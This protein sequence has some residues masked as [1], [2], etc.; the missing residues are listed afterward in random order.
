MIVVHHFPSWFLL[1]LFMLF[2]FSF[3][4]LLLFLYLFLFF[5]SSCLLP[6]IICH[7]S[8]FSLCTS[9]VDCYFFQQT[10]W[11]PGEVDCCSPPDDCCVTHHPIAFYFCFCFSYPH[12]F[13]SVP[14]SHFDCYFSPQTGWWPGQVDHC[15]HLHRL[16]VSLNCTG[17]ATICFSSGSLLGEADHCFYCLPFFQL[18]LVFYLL[19]GR[20]PFSFCHCTFGFSSTA[21]VNC[22]LWFSL[23]EA[24]P[25]F[26]PLHWGCRY[27]FF[28][29]VTTGEADPCFY[30][31]PFLQ[32]TLVFY[33]LFF[34]G[35]NP[36]SFLPLHQP[37]QRLIVACRYLFF[38]QVTAGRSWRLFLLFGW[39]IIF[40]R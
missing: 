28:F 1:L 12:C 20:N 35:R 16:I 7:S 3:S 25:C 19:F 32:L 10:K 11:R 17:A 23:G 36:F 4:F 40:D 34:S 39:L 27:L 22:C 30:R 9:H 38:F 33:L 13:L 5:F 6:T 29:Q 31:S 8:L 2:S 24:D 21:K 26:L 37:P 14:A 18:T 15:C